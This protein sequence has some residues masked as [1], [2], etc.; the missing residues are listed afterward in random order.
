MVVFVN[1]EEYVDYVSCDYSLSWRSYRI[2]KFYD[3]NDKEYVDPVS[4][5]YS[6]PWRSYRTKSYMMNVTDTS[7]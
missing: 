2:K 4:C 6:L 5:D 7:L 1:A 3:V